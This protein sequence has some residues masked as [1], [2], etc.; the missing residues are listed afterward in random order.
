MDWLKQVEHDD[1]VKFICVGCGAE[2][3]FRMNIVMQLDAMNDRSKDTP[4]QVCCKT[5][6]KAMIPESY[7]GKNGKVYTFEEY[8]ELV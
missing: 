4:P 7:T 1:E 6:E 8:K 5:C 2:D 3:N